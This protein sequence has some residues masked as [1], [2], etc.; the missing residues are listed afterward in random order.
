MS[1]T[2]PVS[3]VSS[4]ITA[5]QS[6]PVV[7]QASPGKSQAPST[8]NDASADLRLVIEEDK[9]AGSYVYK[10]V[11]PITGKVISQVP[12]EELLKMRDAPDYRPGALVD[13]RS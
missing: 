10:T 4:E 12:R 1:N 13:S 2:A 3:A 8:Q 6:A 7:S 5:A 9:A 11:D